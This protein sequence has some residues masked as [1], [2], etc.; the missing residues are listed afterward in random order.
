M[1]HILD[2]PRL[3]LRE[4][5]LDDAPF[6]VELVTDPAWLRFIGDRG[7]RDETTACAYLQNGPMAMYAKHGLGLYRVAIKAGD[8]P[9]GMC[10]L[11]KRDN[12]ADI[13]IG[14]AYLPDYRRAGYGFEAAQAMLAYGRDQL[15]LRRI[16]A[17]THVDNTASIALLKRLGLRFEQRVPAHLGDSEVNLFGIQ[18]A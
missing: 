12:V 18:F 16:I 6:I 13:D 8:I 10:G 3:A 7:V 1:A 17:T 2:T 14:F 11:I 15:G 9:I 5:T 4:F